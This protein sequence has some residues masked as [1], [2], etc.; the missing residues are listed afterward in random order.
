[1]KPLALALLLVATPA[2][3]QEV[4]IQCWCQRVASGGV[5]DVD[6]Q[7]F[8][9]NGQSC[10]CNQPMPYTVPADRWLCIKSRTSAFYDGVR[11]VG[12]LTAYANLMHD[13]PGHHG[14][15]SIPTPPQE[16]LDPP[17]AFP[18]GAA[19]LIRVAIRGTDVGT[20]GRFRYAGYLGRDASASR[21]DACRP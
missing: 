14:Y 3:A 15:H 8:T 5:V 4:D 19:L 17:M 11:E 1:V 9:R 16:T 20:W 2:F 6:Q 7:T 13:E 21:E 18:P 10:G 12:G